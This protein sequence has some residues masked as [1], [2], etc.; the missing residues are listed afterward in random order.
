MHTCTHTLTLKHSQT[1]TLTHS[2]SHT[3]MRAHKHTNHSHTHHL[4]KNL[5]LFKMSSVETG[6]FSQGLKEQTN[7]PHDLIHIPGTHRISEVGQSLRAHTA[8]SEDHGSILT[9]YLLSD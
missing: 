2:Q 7:T 4:Q 5:R 6:K 1:H 3:H 8:T 9:L